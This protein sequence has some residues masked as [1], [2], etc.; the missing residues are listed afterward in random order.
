MAKRGYQPLKMKHIVFLETQGLDPDEWLY[1]KNTYESYTFYS[2]PK[3]K[4]WVFRR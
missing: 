1:V 4:E 3:N 2:I